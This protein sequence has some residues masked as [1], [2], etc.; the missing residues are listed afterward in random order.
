MMKV[1]IDLESGD[2]VASSRHSRYPSA[3]ARNSSLKAQYTYRSE[4]FRSISINMHRSLF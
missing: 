1:R 3:L 4:V 2:L